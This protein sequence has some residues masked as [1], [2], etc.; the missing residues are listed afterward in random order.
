MNKPKNYDSPFDREEAVDLEREVILSSEQIKNTDY[1]DYDDNYPPKGSMLN[2]RA[3]NFFPTN[4]S[5]FSKKEESDAYIKY[6]EI[7][8]IN[9]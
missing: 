1:I 3:D 8:N 2:I 7:E 9:D 5:P 4:V 6:K